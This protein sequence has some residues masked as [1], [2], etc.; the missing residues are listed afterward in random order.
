MGD[1]TTVLPPGDPATPTTTADLELHSGGYHKNK[2]TFV[3]DL[4][5]DSTHSPSPHH[6]TTAPL[7]HCLRDA[8]NAMP[9]NLRSRATVP[10]RDPTIHMLKSRGLRVT[11]LHPGYPEPPLSHLSLACLERTEEDAT[12]TYNG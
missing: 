6:C 3:P 2:D 8:Y 10:D 12:H 4:I 5:T 1:F 7:Y 11:V 9:I